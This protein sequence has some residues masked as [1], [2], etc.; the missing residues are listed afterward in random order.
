[1]SQ[2]RQPFSRHP[3]LRSIVVKVDLLTL[4]GT[5]K[6]DAIGASSRGS[7]DIDAP[8]LAAAVGLSYPREVM[9]HPILPAEIDE[10]PDQQLGPTG[11]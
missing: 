2:F 9:P 10:L 4:A 5:M 6:L 8:F 3:R 1:M 11:I 7:K